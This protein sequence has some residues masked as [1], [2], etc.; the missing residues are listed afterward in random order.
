LPRAARAR[1]TGPR[2]LS[3]ISACA[4]TLCKYRMQ[5][6]PKTIGKRDT[7][8]AEQKFADVIFYLTAPEWMQPWNSRQQL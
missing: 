3:G 1:T 5:V 4:S 6:N 7:P 8:M 2:A